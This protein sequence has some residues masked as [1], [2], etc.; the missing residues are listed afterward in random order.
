M[1]LTFSS[2]I[3]SNRRK[4]LFHS[5]TIFKWGGF[6]GGQFSSAWSTV[7]SLKGEVEVLDI[8]S[9]FGIPPTT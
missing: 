8:I 9:L 3:F 7:G 4:L 6:P 2:G 1:F 5:A